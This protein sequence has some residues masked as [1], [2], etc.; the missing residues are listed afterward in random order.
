MVK[1]A[2]RIA[3]LGQQGMFCSQILLTMGLEMRG[4]ENP[5]LVRAASALAGGLGFS[6]GT[7]GSLTGGA[8]LIGLYAGRGTSDEDDTGMLQPMVNDLVD[9]FNERV[10]ER[11]G[12]I[13]CD[14]ILDGKS[15]NMI[16]RCPGIVAETYQHVKDLLVEEGFD[17]GGGA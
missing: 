3:E 14:E 2:D 6:G 11:Y 13:T 15:R 16:D 17:L 8:C 7:C 9:W 1:T 10:G 5:Q 12:G 4:E